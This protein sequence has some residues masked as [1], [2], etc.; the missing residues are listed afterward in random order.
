M[1]LEFWVANSCGSLPE[2]VVNAEELK[3]FLISLNR[4]LML[5]KF[6]VACYS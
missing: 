1:F 5:E 3:I 6:F 2:D 4:N